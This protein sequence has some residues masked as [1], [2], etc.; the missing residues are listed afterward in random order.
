[1]SEDHDIR[2]H[3]PGESAVCTQCGKTVQDRWLEI[4]HHEVGTVEVRVWCR[5]CLLTACGIDP[6]TG[7]SL[8]EDVAS[9]ECVPCDG[10]GTVPPSAV[11]ESAALAEHGSVTLPMPNKPCPNCDGAGKTLTCANCVQPAM[12]ISY[13]GCNHFCWP[14]HGSGEARS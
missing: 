3:Q 2:V 6:E 4:P 12:L 8:P 1:M 10:E 9:S 7:E 5:E 14:C 13:G 11:D